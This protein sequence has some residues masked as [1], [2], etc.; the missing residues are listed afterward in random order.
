MIWKITISFDSMPYLSNTDANRQEMLQSIGA[1]SV[2]ELF[3]MIPDR[4]DGPLDLPNG[5]TELELGQLLRE[6]ESK[7][8]PATE[9]ACFLGCGVYDHFIPAIVDS[10]SSDPRF[11]TAYTPYKAEA[12]QGSLQ[13]FFEYQTL[14]ARLTGMELSNASH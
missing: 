13:T 8:Q 6:L 3:A 12:S 1:A 9:S 4:F 10:L 11:V 14:V 7:L 5:L 2:D